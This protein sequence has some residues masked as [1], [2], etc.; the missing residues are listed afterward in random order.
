MEIIF[1]EI[2]KFT[3]MSWNNSNCFSQ[4]Y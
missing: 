4:I 1:I 2:N 3:H